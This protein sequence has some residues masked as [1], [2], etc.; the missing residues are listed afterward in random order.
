MGRIELSNDVSPL[1]VTLIR[2][3]KFA[4]AQRVSSDFNNNAVDWILQGF[5]PLETKS[6][7]ILST[8]VMLRNS[9]S[10]TIVVSIKEWM[11]EEK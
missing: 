1:A 10:V 5:L 3:A 7:L 9:L 2:Q 4:S 8:T 11:A 6:L